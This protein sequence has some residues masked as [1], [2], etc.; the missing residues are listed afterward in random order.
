MRGGIPHA[1]AVLLPVLAALPPSVH[2]AAAPE[3]ASL[4]PRQAEIF[5][6]T[7]DRPP[8]NGEL[9]R[10]LL[11]P[12]VLELSNPDLSD[13]RIFDRRG[14]EVPYLI[15]QGP[16]ADTEV[17]VEQRFQPRLLKVE[18]AT[19]GGENGVPRQVVETY[20]LTVP[21]EP[22]EGGFWELV[23]ETP[24]RRFVRRVEVAARHGGARGGVEEVLVEGDSVFRLETPPRE[25]LRLALP[26]LT[27]ER[28]WDR[29]VVT[30]Q[31]EDAQDLAPDFRFESTRALASGDEVEVPL[32]LV[33]SREE[34]GRTV[35]EV[36]R[37]RGL[38]PDRLR[39]ATASPAFHW[40]VRVWDE[41]P[42]GGEGAL[43]RG[44]VFRLGDTAR[45]VL[46]LA[47]P[48]GDQ[49]R[50][51]IEH[52]DGPPPEAPRVVA[53]LRRPALVFPAPDAGSE[54]AEAYE[55][56]VLRFG[57]RRVTAPHYGLDALLPALGVPLTGTAARLA[58]DVWDPE[59]L[60]PA[61]LGP[62]GL[63]PVFD[64]APA[65]A[66]AL[67]PGA[68]IDPRRF[69]HRRR[70][71]VP[72]AAEGLHHLRL[73]LDDLAR[74]RPDLADLRIAGTGEH[75]WAYLLETEADHRV[76]PLGVEGPTTRDG[77]SRYRLT[78][79]VQPARADRLVLDTEV[80]FFDRAYEL[81]GKPPG[82][83]EMERLSSGRLRRVLGDPRPVV[84]PLPPRRFTE[85]E[86]LV[87]DGDDAPLVWSRAEARFPVPEV[88][89]AAPEG[90]YELLV[91][92]PEEEAP[93]YELARVRG[94]VLS[95]RSTEVEAG[96]LEPNPAYRASL[97]WATSA[98]LQHLLLW[99]AVLLAV[100]LLTVLTL[101]L[102]RG[103]GEEG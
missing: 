35:L 60:I 54:G 28:A 97:G 18:L 67:H 56:G 90:S 100:V 103:E 21:D 22:P 89:F 36:E 93:S 61:R 13:L 65:L 4:L 85:L 86:L 77:R 45:D 69:S 41:G 33:E 52:G 31:G 64:P 68:A 40:A 87:E 58:E 11:P 14:R 74:L 5:L 49:L 81:S 95:V 20:E 96:P 38:V 63:N 78:L 71:A 82:T 91:G 55:A 12:Q 24:R 26:G 80:A 42:G 8:G 47:L 30:L 84:L 99:G 44:R 79:P 94:V 43:A 17:A 9:A 39:L 46:R 76:R 16:A 102:A 3:L 15:H 53:L 32:A 50:V 92:N 25:R 59:R 27:S 72:D 2:A 73:G 7:A 1:L 75:Q 23:V 62:V 34:P 83:A 101:R 57:A 51:V 98:G 70:L 37:P 88:Y 19:R 66:F 48:R 6:E 10:L 29:L